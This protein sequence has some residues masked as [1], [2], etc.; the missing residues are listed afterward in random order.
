MHCIF[1]NCT[2]LMRRMCQFVLHSSTASLKIRAPFLHYHDKH[3]GNAACIL[4]S[5]INGLKANI[6]LLHTQHLTSIYIHDLNFTPQRQKSHA[7]FKKNKQNFNSLHLMHYPTELWLQFSDHCH[8][9]N[10][11]LASNHLS[12]IV[13]ISVFLA[14]KLLIS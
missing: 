10:E 12:S 1:I 13:L 4:H 2:E 7:A 14:T 8:A 5:S 9:G 11:K 6:T 3:N